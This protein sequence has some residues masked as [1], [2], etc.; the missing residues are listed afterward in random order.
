MWVIFEHLRPSGHM[1]PMC[2]LDI[3]VLWAGA[4]VDS[5]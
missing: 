4:R 3:P 1:V 2:G 5:S